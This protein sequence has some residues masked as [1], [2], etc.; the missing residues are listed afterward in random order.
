MTTIL[1]EHISM[2]RPTLIKDGRRKNNAWNP[3]EKKGA[4]NSICGKVVQV[5]VKVNSGMVLA[6]QTP[7]MHIDV[8]KAFQTDPKQVS[9]TGWRLD[10]GEEL[11]R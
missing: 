11:W 7:A 9:R 1:G 10:T 3:V 8:L 4:C 2:I 6:L 5:L